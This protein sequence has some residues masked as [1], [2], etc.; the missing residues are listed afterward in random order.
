[1]RTYVPIR[2]HSPYSISEGAIHLRDLAAFAARH[3]IPAVAV[4]DTDTLAG[5]YSIRDARLAKGVQPIHA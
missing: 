4:A 5:A 2:V 1:M 3:A